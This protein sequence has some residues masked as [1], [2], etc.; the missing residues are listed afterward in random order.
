MRNGLLAIFPI[1]SDS[2]PGEVCA[3]A[4]AAA[5]EARGNVAALNQATRTGIGVVSFGL[6]LHIGNVLYGNIGGGNRLDFTCI[7]PAVNLA[8]RL[9]NLLA[10]WAE[11]LSPLTNSQAIVGLTFSRSE[12]FLW[13]D[14]PASRTSSVPLMK[15][16]RWFL[17]RATQRQRIDLE[18]CKS[19]SERSSTRFYTC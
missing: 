16:A 18:K 6:A 3:R 19:G 15:Q 2:D 12:N 14:L 5:Y 13:R 4:L 9:R 8:A 17:L 10:N 7:G 1:G 11:S